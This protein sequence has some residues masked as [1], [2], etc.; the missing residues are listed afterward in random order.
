MSP[1][2]MNGVCRARAARSS[3]IVQLALRCRRQSM[4]VKRSLSY[5]LLLYPAASTR[6]QSPFEVLDVAFKFI[7]ALCERGRVVAGRVVDAFQR[8]D[9]ARNLG[10]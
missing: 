10:P 3:A 6:T 2:L 1:E 9:E 4:S 8:F 5:C 7:D